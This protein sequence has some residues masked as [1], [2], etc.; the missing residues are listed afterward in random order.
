MAPAFDYLRKKAAR[1]QPFCGDS[2]I[3]IK[4]TKPSRNPCFN[5]FYCVFLQVELNDSPHFWG[6]LGALF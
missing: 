3:R 6:T 4:N 5:D 2:R 1:R